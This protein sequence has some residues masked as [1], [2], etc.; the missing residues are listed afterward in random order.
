VSRE[1]G[2]EGGAYLE[3]FVCLGEERRRRRTHKG[4]YEKQMKKLMVSTCPP[5]PPSLPPSLR[6]CHPLAGI[7]KSSLNGPD[8]IFQD[9]LKLVGKARGAE[10][11]RE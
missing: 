5:L 7:G 6:T 1:G 9:P 8:D 11:G 10:G 2:R 4:T 3:G